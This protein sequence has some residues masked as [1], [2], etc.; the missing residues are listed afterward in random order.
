MFFEV[1]ETLEFCV[2]F[3]G[4]GHVRAERESFLWLEV[5]DGYI[6]RVLQCSFKVPDAN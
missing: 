4:L 2:L 5:W 3:S 6:L 1:V